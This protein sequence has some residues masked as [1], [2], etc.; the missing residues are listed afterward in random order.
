MFFKKKFR[1]II[2]L[3]G[4]KVKDKDTVDGFIRSTYRR[5]LW[6]Y[7]NCLKIQTADD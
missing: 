2:V 5:N 1:I 7:M 6:T 3:K 4:R